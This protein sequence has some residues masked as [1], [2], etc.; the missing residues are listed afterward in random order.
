MKN[1]LVGTSSY[2]NRKWSGIFYP[3]EIPA[4]GWFEFY[5]GVF[6]T[7]EIN[8]TFYRFPGLK[9]MQTWYKKTPPGFILSV[10]APK[11]ITHLNKFVDSKELIQK[12]YT[13][14]SDG[15]AEKLGAILFQLP[16]SFVYSP[17]N[18]LLITSSLDDKF[19][20]VIEFRHSSWWNE[21]VF[22]ALR[23]NNITFC[24]VGYPGLPDQPVLTLELVYFRLHGS[25]RLFYSEYSEPELLSIYQWLQ[26][27]E[28]LAKAYIYFNN[29]ASEAGIRNAVYYHRLAER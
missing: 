25:P 9:S 6:N 19:Q 14:C 17:E 27:N 15:L 4:S 8:A 1:I 21:E 22:G 29:T 3:E 24:N 12:F 18:L 20:N 13:V 28:Q 26:S 2:Y 16:P 23:D 5:T 11:Q 7:F 10:K